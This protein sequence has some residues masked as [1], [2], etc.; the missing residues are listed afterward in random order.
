MKKK[1]LSRVSAVLMASLLLS[2]FSTLS[3]QTN[4]EVNAVELTGQSAFD[5]TS[6]MTI[7]WNLGNTL[8]CANTGFKSTTAPEKFATKWGNPVPTKELF[9]TVQN[10]G[11]NTVRIPTTWYEHLEYN[12]DDDFYYINDTW[13]DYVQQTVDYAYDLGMFIILNVHHEDWVNASEFT[14]E[15]FTIA[16]KKLS[17]I[18]SQ[19]SETFADYDQHLIFEGMNEPRQ[20]GLG[21]SV[22]WGSGD[23]YSRTY[24]NNLNAVFMNTV[25][26]QGSSANAERLLMLP[27]YC[28]SSDFNAIRAIEIPENAGNVALSVHAYSPYF[29]TMDSGDYANHTF[30]GKSGYGEDYEMSLTNLFTGLKSISDDKNVPIIIGEFSASN[31]DNTDS[32]VAWAKDYLTKAKNAGIPCVLWD[33]NN[34]TNTDG[35]AHGYL[36]RLTNTWYDVSAPVIEAMMSVYDIT[37]NLPA[38]EPYVEPEF[39]W[40]AIPV[41]D[42]WV[43]LFRP[44][45]GK[46]YKAWQNGII[47]NWKDY[48]NENY[49]IVFVYQSAAEPYLVLQG[50][51]TSWNQVYSTGDNDNF[52]MYFTYDDVLTSME[53]NGTSLDEM[54]NLYISA[55][56]ETMT[57]YGLFAVPK[58]N[59]NPNPDTLKG[60][61]NADD[62][63]SILDIIKL[64]KYLICKESFDKATWEKADMN[65]DNIVNIYDLALLKNAILKTE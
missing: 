34:I 5:I 56:S 1:M 40:D 48:I 19:V 4:L 24:I 22:E 25:R 54:K 37:P 46:E 39:S 53:Q 17:D 20:T 26:N 13:M 29:F 11:F 51:G 31:F 7:G 9:E 6:Q 61:L 8:D 30:P 21:S 3:E 50:E 42:D 38:Y 27:G 2:G 65:N 23:D 32:R 60:D 35:E 63:I 43:E 52:M 10:A 41:G 58:E 62:E 18:W 36:Y 57:A 15:S 59:P 47:S 49:D 14:D 45:S 12:E 64:Q 55:S 16:S 44:E 33:N 28:A